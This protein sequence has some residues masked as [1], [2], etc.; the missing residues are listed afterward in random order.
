MNSV[1]LQVKTEE[2]Q[3]EASNCIE[4]NWNV[5]S[6]RIDIVIL[7][8]ECES[9]SAYCAQLRGPTYHADGIVVGCAVIQK[10]PK[11]PSSNSGYQLP[12]LEGHIMAQPGCGILFS[13]SSQ[14]IDRRNSLRRS[15]S[16]NPKAKRHTT[17][18]PPVTSLQGPEMGF[19]HHT[20]SRSLSDKV[21]NMQLRKKKEQE[22]YAGKP[23][24]VYMHSSMNSTRSR[25]PKHMD[26]IEAASQTDSDSLYRRQT[27]RMDNRTH[28]DIGTGKENMHKD[29]RNTQGKMCNGDQ[30]YRQI[31]YNQYLSQ[32]FGLDNMGGSKPSAGAIDRLRRPEMPI[33]RPDSDASAM[34]TDSME[35]NFH[36]AAKDL[37]APCVPSAR[38]RRPKIQVQIPG[39]QPS[40][41]RPTSSAH[42][43]TQINRQKTKGRA[44]HLSTQISP[45]SATSSQDCE[46]P[47]RLSIVSPLSVMEMPK[48]RRPFS[49]WSL[50]DMT[51]ESTPVMPKSAPLMQKTKS[52]DSSD[53]TGEADD[54]SSTY[55]RSSSKS[56][57]T[58][59]T[60]MTKA[61]DCRHS[62]AFSIADPTMAGV[63]D[64][65]PSAPKMPA[66]LRT[67]KSSTSLALSIN[68][69]LPPEP[70]LEEIRPLR[71]PSQSYSHGCNLHPK[72]KAPS[73]LNISRS[74]SIAGLPQ[75]MSSLRSKYTPADLDALDA[76]FVKSSPQVASF[77][78][79]RESSWEQAQSAL[80]EHLGTIA[81]DDSASGIT[82]PLAC[83]PLQISRGPNEMVPSRQAPPPPPSSMSIK[84]S[85]GSISS[86]NRLQKHSSE[87]IMMQMKS[88]GNRSSMELRKRISAPVGG[89]MIKANRILGKSGTDDPAPT[90]AAAAIQ[91]EREASSESNWSSSESPETS[92]N[93]DSS[94]PQMSNRGDTSTPETDVSSIPDH[95][96]EEVKARLELLSP[97][98]DSPSVFTTWGHVAPSSPVTL[99]TQKYSNDFSGPGNSEGESGPNGQA[100]TA[101]PETNLSPV[102]EIAEFSAEIAI[103]LEEAEEMFP[104]RPRE[105]QEG[106]QEVL[107]PRSLASIAM[108]E[109]PDIYAELP[110]PD[111]DLSAEDAD[112]MISADA[113]E[114]VLLRILEN[115][116]NLQ[117]LFATATVSR[118]FYRTFKRHELPLM[119][120]ALYG[121]SPAA[122]ELREM[123]PPY[124]G[125][126][127]EDNAA[128]RLD[129]TPTL[130]L[131]HY[132]RDMYT[133]IALKSMILIHCESFLRADT[134]TALAGG[135]TERASQ[136]DDAFWRVWSFCQ[137]F[138]C[139]SN[140]EDDIVAQMDWLRGGP[141]AKKQKRNR[142]P[143][144][145]NNV[146]FAPRVSFGYGNAGGLSA[147]DLYD[148][149]E[150]WTCLGVLVRGFQGKRQEA[151]EFGVFD[152]AKDLNA[153][154]VEAE[155]SLLGMLL[156]L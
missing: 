128:P 140:R 152:N 126:Q 46:A 102:P 82:V 40:I 64:P 38:D 143:D 136:I 37:M 85:D 55:S 127:G 147:E 53:D 141:V 1:T 12:P 89:S 14:R 76:A 15:L 33:A 84:L 47:A 96:F 109:I 13:P 93:G 149:T 117:D 2:T 113:A 27:P 104:A 146:V 92:Y 120:N 71:L 22:I 35:V 28:P 67:M 133:M 60:T 18:R 97:K 81:E 69:P 156:Q 54:R 139:G 88:D 116:D 122:W 119:K 91:M 123:T 66:S 73:P 110:S 25:N 101:A 70:C 30:S 131:Q 5:G 17:D 135:E 61:E 150:I 41:K 151:R 72:R 100:K 144:S 124:P 148:M 94:S 7:V 74:S 63:F 130:Y 142:N 59:D 77:G 155:D 145:R 29:G 87:H 98:N 48:P 23:Q 129:Y 34:T 56:S 106:G 32:A 78:H 83:D 43:A 112:R 57:L 132:M 154:D 114:K 68:K 8:P 95:A 90:T 108:S 115:L 134:I 121:M 36:M 6:I 137:I 79:A 45:P 21:R 62:V 138:G 65:T 58:S 52:A 3:E 99:S 9:S 31:A 20:H 49:A 86:R 118:G 51:N 4:T 111:E 50:E 153:G 107:R 19:V 44:R 16:L 26:L 75:R 39:K 80:E 103:N 42:L 11:F 105:R 24:G 10:H 125:L